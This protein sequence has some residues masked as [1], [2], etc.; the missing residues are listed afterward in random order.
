MPRPIPVFQANRITLRPPNP[1][2]DARDYYTLNLDPDMPTGDTIFSLGSVEE[3][4]EELER[5]LAL[6]L[7]STWMVVENS[8][9][10]VVGR[11]FLSLE[12][13]DGVLVAGEG[14]RF[15]R[16]Y[17]RKGY[18]LDAR[19]LLLPYVFEELGADWIE[20]A[21]WADNGPRI[22]ALEGS[23]FQ[24]HHEEIEWNE[25]QADEMAMRHYV[26]TKEQWQAKREK[27]RRAYAH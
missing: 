22:E 4:R 3:A 10:R 23:G 17:W 26:L 8:S 21:V 1:E 20:S 2:E 16:P 7:I 18:K 25:R 11:F 12:D 24:L 19:K 6:P 27:A 5:T 13:R 9:N 14:S 15:A